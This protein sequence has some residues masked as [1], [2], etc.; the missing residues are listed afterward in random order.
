M[1]PAGIRFCIFLDIFSEAFRCNFEC[2]GYRTKMDDFGMARCGFDIVNSTSAFVYPKLVP[3]A[4]WR[5]SCIDVG[6][7]MVPFG[8]ALVNLFALFL[9]II[10]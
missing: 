8:D 6:T 3:G 2:Q 1:H 7:I 9:E 5:Q 10:F 4:A